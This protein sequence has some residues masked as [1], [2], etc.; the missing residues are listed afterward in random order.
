SGFA[1]CRASLTVEPNLNVVQ[2]PRCVSPIPPSSLE[3]LAAGTHTNCPDSVPVTKECYLL[4]ATMSKCPCGIQRVLGLSVF[5]AD[6]NATCQFSLFLVLTESE[7]CSGVL[8]RTLLC[9]G[10]CSSKMGAGLM[11]CASR[12]RLVRSCSC[13]GCCTWLHSWFL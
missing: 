5:G 10:I 7:R 8:H 3:V 9:L 11:F 13:C 4:V 12:R 2:L 1:D 6:W